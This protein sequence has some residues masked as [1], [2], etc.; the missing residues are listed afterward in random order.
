MVC[1]LIIDFLVDSPNMNVFNAFHNLQRS[2]PRFCDLELRSVA[3]VPGRASPLAA[4]HLYQEETSAG[5]RAGAA[6]SPPP[7][8]ASPGRALRARHVDL[9]EVLASTSPLSHSKNQSFIY[10]GN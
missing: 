8:A 7:A 6:Q 3:S 2:V 5:A 10:D 9:S 1:G 4:W